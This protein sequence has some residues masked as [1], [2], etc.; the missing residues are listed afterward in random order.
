MSAASRDTAADGPE[1]LLRAIRA[2]HDELPPVLRTRNQGIAACT[3]PL[4]LPDWTLDA[5]DAAASAADS[6][7]HR[8]PPMRRDFYTGEVF[9]ERQANFT[10][11]A[12]DLGDFTALRCIE[13]DNFVIDLAERRIVEEPATRHKFFL[14]C[15]GCA[16]FTVRQVQAA[17]GR[18]L[19]M[20]EDCDRFVVSDVHSRDYEGY[21]LILLHSRLFQIRRC[22]FSG[23]LA[24]GIMILGDCCD[25]T[26]SECD[27]SESRGYYNW[28]AGL[29]ICH[30]S[31]RIAAAQV[32]ELC[33]E[34]LPIRLK[35]MRPTRI[36]V[37]RSRF[38]ANRA[39][40]IYLEGA[41]ECLL[42]DNDIADN[43][44]EGICLDWGTALCVLKGNRIGG[45]GYRSNMGESEIKI[46][47][48]EDF[49]LLPD[50]S[51]TCKLPGISFDNGVLNAVID[52]RIH[53]NH[54]GGVKMVR[55]AVAN[56][57]ACNRFSD[58][59]RGANFFVRKMHD[60]LLLSM[61]NRGGEFDDDRNSLL[62]F[63]GSSFNR[64][65]CNTFAAD[66]SEAIHYDH[67]YNRIADNVFGVRGE[68]P[69]PADRRCLGKVG[70][71]TP[72]VESDSRGP[73][74]PTPCRPSPEISGATLY[75]F[76]NVT[77]KHH[78]V[79]RLRPDGVIEFSPHPNESHWRVD[80]EQLLFFDQAFN[81]TTRFEAYS[82]PAEPAAF[83]GY[84]RDKAVLHYLI[85]MISTEQSA[86]R[87]ETLPP[88]FINAMPHCPTSLLTQ[89]FSGLGWIATGLHCVPS[90]TADS[91]LAT[92][93][94]ALRDI[95][96][97][98]RLFPFSKLASI[99]QAGQFLSGTI[100]WRAEHQPQADR[101]FCV[102][103][104]RNLREVLVSRCMAEERSARSNGRHAWPSI[105]DPG[106]RFLAFLDLFAVTNRSLTDF[107][108]W[109]DSDRALILRIEDLVKKQAPS[110]LLERLAA[111]GIAEAAV[112]AVLERITASH[113]AAE[114]DE[115]SR[116]Q[117]YWSDDAERLFASSGLRAMN[118][119]L[120]YED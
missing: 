107:S 34:P 42:R 28:D 97:D 44:K 117:R 49:P 6:P 93:P 45:N 79:I 50:R 113:A 89:L 59:D 70:E 9:V 69:I 105:A 31:R 58:N 32:P 33:H 118:Q 21:G 82:R 24:S 52:N 86:P 8:V 76:G 47:F 75:A 120:G 84:F 74:A 51:S 85:P 1:D 10:L 61:G 27:C 95:R 40:G 116:W 96:G 62:D 78:A 25:G 18:N 2:I 103:G 80:G 19:A 26:V 16:D 94:A 91:S 92:D 20:L 77:D 64:I 67:E 41:R 106:H 36:R 66:P 104:T 101:L 53:D 22:R 7:R 90:G 11:R 87:S 102:C 115:P 35:T 13:C 63:Y 14:H 17:G 48:I 112:H 30:C 37:E 60:V 12:A 71:P 83:V 39:Q 72:S 109:I 65:Q 54:G 98:D 46:D 57:V 68:G 114:D 108:P 23:H 5:A 4:T 56:L 73:R 29:H 88:L 15:Y 3:L 110:P 38:S 81:V 99:V 100:P 43:N 111:F 119:K 55:S